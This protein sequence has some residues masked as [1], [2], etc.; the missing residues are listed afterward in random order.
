[1]QEYVYD[2]DNDND[3]CYIVPACSAGAPRQPQ[4]VA[5]LREKGVL[6]DAEC[7][8]DLAMIAARVPLSSPC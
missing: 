7:W 2:D 6:M 3:D 5:G 1:M 8:G 4:P